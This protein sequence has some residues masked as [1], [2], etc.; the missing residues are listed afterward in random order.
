MPSGSTGSAV[1]ID[2]SGVLN[3]SDRRLKENISLL[4]NTLSKLDQLGGYN[5]NYKADEKK[6]KQIGVIA[7]ELEKVFPELVNTDDRG[8]KMVNYQGLI[9]VLMQAIKEQQIEINQLNQKVANQESKLSKLESDNKEMKN[10]LDLIKKMLL[11]EESAKKDN[12]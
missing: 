12:K 3:S 7:Q 11:G 2:G 8:Y 10:D 1:F 9:P 5:Y 4:Q 6:K